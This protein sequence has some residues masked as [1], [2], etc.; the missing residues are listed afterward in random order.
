[1]S[2]LQWFLLFSGFRVYSVR[3]SCPKISRDLKAW[4]RVQGFGVQD[5]KG[6]LAVKCV[7]DAFMQG[8][9]SE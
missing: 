8:V 9:E 6:S 4:F 2:I 1:M 3:P 5:F 7:A